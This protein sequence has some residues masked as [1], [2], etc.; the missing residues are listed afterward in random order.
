L[1]QKIVGKLLSRY[2]V[3]AATGAARS[4]YAVA[5]KGLDKIGVGGKIF[6]AST[7]IGGPRTLAATKLATPAQTAARTAN[8]VKNAANTAE[9]AGKGA[10]SGGGTAML[11]DIAKGKRI[12]KDATA[13]I[14]AKNSK[15]TPKKK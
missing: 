1:A 11:R 9:A 6:E 13:L 2:V 8:L 14:V 12:V 5:S 4:T 7:A 3:P 15:P 10:L